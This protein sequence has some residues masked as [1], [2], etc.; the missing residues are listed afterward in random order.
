MDTAQVVRRKIKPAD[1]LQDIRVAM[2]GRKLAKSANA[3]VDTEIESLAGSRFDVVIHKIAG[4]KLLMAT[5]SL[6]P[7]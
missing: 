7:D 1:V 6:L 5:S 4:I 2:P 3:I